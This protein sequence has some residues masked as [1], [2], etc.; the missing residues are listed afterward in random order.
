[1]ASQPIV[2]DEAPSENL[3]EYGGEG[4]ILVIDDDDLVRELTTEVLKEAGYTVMSAD[5]GADALALYRLHQPFSV[6][7][8]DMIMPEQSGDLVFQQLRKI[9]GAQPALFIS[10]YTNEQVFE[11]LQDWE[12]WRYLTKPFTAQQLFEAIGEIVQE[13]TA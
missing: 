12:G 11:Q 4:K 6:V 1:M 10:G 9:N 3:F 8:I 13:A 5:S 2:S 7:I